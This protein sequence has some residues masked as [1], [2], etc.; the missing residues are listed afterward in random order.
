PRW[1]DA[2]LDK[3]ASEFAPSTK[4]KATKA[5]AHSSRVTQ[6][7]EQIQDNG[8][9]NVDPNLDV[10]PSVIVIDSSQET[11]EQQA[12]NANGRQAKNMANNRIKELTTLNDVLVALDKRGNRPKKKKTITDGST[13]ELTRATPE[14]QE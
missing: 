9:D 5:P 6:N 14:P 2:D 1:V 7:V 11:S 3:M 12:Q 4:R 8:H 10:D 13:T